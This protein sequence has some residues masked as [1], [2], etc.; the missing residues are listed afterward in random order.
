V[1]ERRISDDG[2]FVTKSIHV[3]G[4]GRTFTERVRLYERAD[5]EMLFA[6]RGVRMETALGDYDGAPHDAASPRLI[7][8]GR[9]A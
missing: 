2:R 1:Q 3:S 5:I 8:L 7:L 6:A 9:R 4:N